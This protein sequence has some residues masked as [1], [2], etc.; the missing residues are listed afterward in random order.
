MQT[1]NIYYNEEIVYTGTKLILLFIL[2]LFSFVISTDMIPKILL[3]R[4]V[5]GGLI[6]LSVSHYAFIRYRPDTLVSLRK[7]V[8]ISL[9]LLTLTLL[10]SIFEKYGLF[11]LPFYVLIVMQSGLG[12][13]KKYIYTSIVAA[14]ISW[15]LLLIFSPYW[16]ANYDIIIAFAIT[17]LLVSLFSLRFIEGVDETHDEAT[18]TVTATEPSI[19]HEFLAGIADRTM[20]KEMFRDTLKKKET[21]SLLFISLDNFQAI[22]DKHGSQIAYTVL[23]E[24]AKRLNKSMDKDDFL[25]RLGNNEFVIISKRQRV[26]L[27][28]FLKKLEDNTIGAYHIDGINTHI[29]LSIGVSLYPENGKSAMIL[30]KCAD[31]AMRSA[32]ENPNAHH[33][34]YEGTKS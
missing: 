28:K 21:F 11:L 20:Y 2:T 10:I 16:Y 8:S 23:E 27:R 1:Q 14:A 7:N 31:D 9:D 33:M 34:F 13:G 19:R 22:T 6:L 17:T 32:K 29:E 25:A 3:V 30:S 4:L 24:A 26:F 18:E 5:L 15:A 12:F